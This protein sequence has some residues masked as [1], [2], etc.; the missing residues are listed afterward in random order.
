MVIYYRGHAGG[1]WEPGLWLTR[2]QV[3]GL[4]FV[5]P[6]P[7]VPLKFW[8]ALNPKPCRHS[9]VGATYR[10]LAIRARAFGFLGAS[11]RGRAPAFFR[12]KPFDVPSA[13]NPARSDTGL[14]AL[15]YEFW[16]TSNQAS[17]STVKAHARLSACAE[18]T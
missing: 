3:Q 6:D 2:F 1:Y 5:T 10:K 17:L 9:W 16:L 13:L 14:R 11:S 15:R 18:G 7:A 8:F 4:G 12:V